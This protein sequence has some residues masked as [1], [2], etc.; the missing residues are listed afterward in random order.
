MS[1]KSLLGFFSGFPT[2]HFT[3]EIAIFVKGDVFWKVGS[4]YRIDKGVITPFEI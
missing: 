2:H 4:I 1:R 3:D